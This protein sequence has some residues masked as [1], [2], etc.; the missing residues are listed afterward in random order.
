[1]PNARRTLAVF[2]AGV[3]ALSVWS[4]HPTEGAAVPQLDTIRVGIFMNTSKYALNTATA[5]FSSTGG[6]K[7]GMRLPSSVVPMFVSGSDETVRFTMDDY[8]PI[9]L[10]TTDYLAATAVV[11]RLKALGGS[12]MMIGLN[13]ARGKVYQISEGSYATAAAAGAAGDKWLKDGT[14]AGYAGKAAKADLMG[15]LHLESGMIFASKNE[16]VAAA[17]KLAASGIEAYAAIKQSGTAA[18][19]YTVLLGSESDQAA[20][21]ALGTKAQQAE[22]GLSPTP[23]DPKSLYVLIRDDYTTAESVSKPPASLYSVP[24][25]GA[26]LWLET[27]ADTGIKLA[28]RY[29]RSYRGAFEVSGLGNRMAVVNEVPFEQYISAV[30]GAEMPASWPAEALK[31]QAVAARTYAL[32]QGFGFQIAHVVD[33]TLSQAYG[34]I[35]SEKAATIAAVEATQGEVAMYGGKVINTVFSSSAGGFTADAQEIWGSSFDYLKSVQSPDTSSE[36]GLYKWYRVVTPN[37]LVGYIREDLLEDS[38]QKSAGGQAVLRVKSAGTKVRPIPL[39]Q[40]TVPVVD[41]VNA[42]A[43]V[44]SLEKVTQSNEMS[45]VRGTYSAAEL[46]KLTQ[47]KLSKPI[48]GPIRTL[49]ISKQGPSGRPT[50][51]TANGQ[52]LSV[53]TPDAFRS[54]FGGLPSTLFK[55]DE[56]ARLTIAGSGGATTEKPADGSAMYILGG[57]GKKQELTAPNYFIVNGSGTV[58]AATKEPEFRFVG[59]GNGHGV[60]LSQYGAR[61][62]AGLGYDYKYIMQY[63]YKDAK[64]VKE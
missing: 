64:I 39:V 8:K 13:D 36:N 63:Y 58:R 33:T 12:G 56:T 38:G 21:S 62:L 27:T 16:A 37:N 51:I 2:G 4:S 10:E 18:G 17:Q 34:G 11:K 28:E 45:W 59:S 26:K 9:V 24:L 54:A 43:L 1:M 50:E 52:A 57:D 53:K 41:T 29:G 22:S 19:V 55:I 6:M 20:L 47:G 46:L 48:A 31:A 44:V 32:Y 60:G 14:I 3:I 23:T 5:T 49:E 30:V 61:G 25:T 40:D 7:V 15:P 35:G 42:G